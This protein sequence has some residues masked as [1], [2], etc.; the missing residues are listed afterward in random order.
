MGNC[1]GGDL[2][3][4]VNVVPQNSPDDSNDEGTSDWDSYEIGEKEIRSVFDAVFYVFDKE[5]RGYLTTDQFKT[6]MTAFANDCRP[7][8][9]ISPREL[10]SFQDIL[11][12]DK[13]GIVEQNEFVSF[14]FDLA[15]ITPED[16]AA[17]VKVCSLLF[18]LLLIFSLPA[19]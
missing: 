9:S 1:L 8:V 17:F 18:F 7:P 10:A 14:F 6:L 16:R 12:K 15:W 5:S 3:S 4:N 11:D 19:F 2:S 13:N